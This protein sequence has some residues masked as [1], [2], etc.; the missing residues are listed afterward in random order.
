MDRKKILICGGGTAGWFSA[1]I[2]HKDFDITL[3]ESNTIPPIGVGESVT[4]T[5]VDVLRAA[6]ID[7]K[8]FI[9]KTNS[10]VKYGV[11]FVN[12][13]EEEYFHPFGE[14]FI[15]RLFPDQDVLTDIFKAGKPVKNLSPY[16]QLALDDI[17]PDLES[18]DP[19]WWDI[20]LHWQN[21]L[22][23]PY[24]RDFLKGKI[25]HHY[26]TIDDND[27]II[28]DNGVVSIKGHVADYYVDCTGQKRLL[29][30]PFDIKYL[31]FDDLHLDSALVYS[32]EP[33]PCY[34]TESIKREHGWEWSIPLQDRNNRGYVYSSKWI[35]DEEARAE[36]G[37]EGGR[38]LRF[39]AGALSKIAY[40]NVLSNG[41]AAHF[42]EPL[43]ATNIEFIVYAAK[44]FGESIKSGYDYRELD[45]TLLNSIN[46]IKD[47]ILLHYY[48]DDRFDTDFNV[49]GFSCLRI[50][51]S[52][53]FD[54]YSVCC[55][56]FS[57]STKFD[58]YLL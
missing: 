27:V 32:K 48:N 4:E 38:I 47:F 57:L 53:N 14:S 1:L 10:T 43:E 40:K 30:H 26:D 9:S 34:Y 2:L 41:L 19:F 52:T 31:P 50:S 21:D 33:D 16:T 55:L 51:V 24:L 29:S 7:L 44:L 8:N 23:A 35:S 11:N 42:V 49:Y 56:L 36:M 39:E 3:I 15:D 46:E 22:V 37:I 58:V 12:W 28:D 45:A 54:V 5:V 20:A 13:A 18:N 17:P 6:D 25:N